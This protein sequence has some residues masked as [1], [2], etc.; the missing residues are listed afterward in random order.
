MQDN[1]LH[2]EH[3]NDIAE[4]KLRDMQ[5]F[6][7][8]KQ[9]EQK[10]ELMT[11]IQKLMPEIAKVYPQMDEVRK[12][13]N[14]CLAHVTHSNDRFNALQDQL[15]RLEQDQYTLTGRMT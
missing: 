3:Q 13:T 11:Q 6:I 12:E 14:A 8:L 2:L 5:D 10:Q 1:I 4:N 9:K 15:T 7:L